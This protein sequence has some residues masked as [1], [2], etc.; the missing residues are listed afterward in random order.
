[1]IRCYGL[2]VTRQ[3]ASPNSDDLLDSFVNAWDCDVDMCPVL[4]RGL[5]RHELNKARI[6]SRL[7][8]S[9]ELTCPTGEP[10]VLTRDGAPKAFADFKVIDVNDEGAD[11]TNR[12]SLTSRK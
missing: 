7:A 2:G 10:Y 3:W 1:V 12:H 9:R 8:N 6:L 11:G 4:Q 5:L